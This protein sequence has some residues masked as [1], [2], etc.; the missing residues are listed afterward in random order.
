[1][2]GSSG[3]AAAYAALPTMT[4]ATDAKGG[5][6]DA[7]R[8]THSAL[9]V[10]KDDRVVLSGEGGEAT[11]A[12]A[13]TGAAEA[14]AATEHEHVGGRRP[15]ASMGASA[16]TAQRLPSSSGRRGARSM[17]AEAALERVAVGAR[18]RAEAAMGTLKEST[19][20]QIVESRLRR[21]GVAVECHAT[22]GGAGQP[23]ARA[24]AAAHRG[25]AARRR[26]RPLGSCRTLFDP[27]GATRPTSSS[28]FAPRRR[29]SVRRTSSATPRHSLAARASTR[30]RVSR[31]GNTTS[32]AA[33]RSDGPERSAEARGEA[34]AHLAD[35]GGE[36]C[37]AEDDLSEGSG[38]ES[39]EWS[40][41]DS[42]SDE[43]SEGGSDAEIAEAAHG[44]EHL[45]P[46]P[47]AVAGPTLDEGTLRRRAKVTVDEDLTLTLT[48]PHPHPHPGTLRRAAKHAVEE[49]AIA[50]DDM[51][52][53][54][55]DLDGGWRENAQG[56]EM[57]RL[58][59]SICGGLD[60][61]VAHGNLLGRYQ[62][63]AH[64]EQAAGGR[65]L[66]PVSVSADARA[67]ARGGASRAH[68]AQ[69]R[70][71]AMPGA[72]AGALPARAG[73]VGSR[74]RCRS[75]SRPRPHAGTLRSS[76][77]APG[78]RRARAGS[79]MRRR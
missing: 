67:A 22:H 5:R 78:A 7:T 14:G 21:L 59:Y 48:L 60:G 79:R 57:A 6:V 10:S 35:A 53:G 63:G 2:D 31:G 73:S 27:E 75:S 12:M 9:L 29:C 34:R 41:G 58:L 40:Y 49:A 44:S 19:P 55:C 38:S 11:S 42:G 20:A 43:D 24:A 23:R 61:V 13:A 36:A 37:E 50:S 52:S 25:R 45:A 39:G 8:P 51:P 62:E 64:L 26:R 71:D 69:V 47:S 66:H 46:A 77:S 15:P 3:G 56:A 16:S 30:R 76:C 72:H 4:A 18:A 28:C 68:A 33:E 65:A 17:S 54:T 1:M 32:R 74:R 70:G